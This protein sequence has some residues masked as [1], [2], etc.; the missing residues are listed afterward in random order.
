MVQASACCPAQALAGGA[1]ALG[2]KSNAFFLNT[3]FTD[4]TAT[5]H[6]PIS[7]REGTTWGD[8][9]FLAA[10]VGSAI[11]YSNDPFLPKVQCGHQHCSGLWLS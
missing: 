5:A 8:D 9:I 11:Y 6:D 2:V 1:A 10:P 3:S 4:N 7:M